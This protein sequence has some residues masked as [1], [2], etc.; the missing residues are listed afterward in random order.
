MRG[1]KANLSSHKVN[2]IYQF[3]T[4]E[5]FKDL[6]GEESPP[7]KRMS[8]NRKTN[9]VLRNFA[10]HSFD[11]QTLLNRL[12]LRSNF[13]DFRVLANLLWQAHVSFSVPVHCF[14]DSF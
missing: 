7:G 3:K 6:C 8:H 1:Q 12:I 9:R 11:E 10:H 14:C 2:L 13:H 4:E 5:C